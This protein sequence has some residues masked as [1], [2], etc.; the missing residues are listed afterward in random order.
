MALPDDKYTYF[1]S[2]VSGDGSLN[3][4]ERAWYNLAATGT[5][6]FNNA[7]INGDVSV[8]GNATFAKGGTF[9]AK[10]IINDMLELRR[11][12]FSKLILTN[13]TAN[14][15]WT[16][17]NSSGDFA[18]T[19]NSIQALTVNSTTFMAEFYGG[20]TF[21]KS[22]TLKTVLNLTTSVAVPATPATGAILFIDSA[23]NYLKVK[24]S[25][26]ATVTLASS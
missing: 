19:K 23:D 8:N 15:T 11:P 25:T 10:V 3:D 1:K 22:V 17:E 26:G 7:T 16:A 12:N 24:F 6:V 18:L 9:N 4:L 21:D 13:T 5:V 20:A 2:I 14:D